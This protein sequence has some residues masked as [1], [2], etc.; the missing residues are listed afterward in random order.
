[1]LTKQN[2]NKLNIYLYIL[3]KYKKKFVVAT[4][5]LYRLELFFVYD[6]I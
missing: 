6:K 1:M 5:I 2:E 4:V 3:F